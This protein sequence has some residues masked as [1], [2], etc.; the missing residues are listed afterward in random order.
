MSVVLGLPGDYTSACPGE[1]DAYCTKV[2]G[3]MVL[4][5]EV[6]AEKVPVPKCSNCKDEMSLIF[7]ASPHSAFVAASKVLTDSIHKI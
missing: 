2:G 3:A 7:Q 4:P 1:V 5:E 6:A